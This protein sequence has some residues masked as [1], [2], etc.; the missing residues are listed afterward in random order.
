M[1]AKTC[2]RTVLMSLVVTAFAPVLHA[3]PRPARTV[4]DDTI[5]PDDPKRPSIESVS[6]SDAGLGF[7][8]SIRVHV[9]GL[10]CPSKDKAADALAKEFQ[11]WVLYLDGRP[12]SK[13]H[14]T[15]VDV[16]RGNF[17]FEMRRNDDS[18]EAWRILFRRL[19]YWPFSQPVEITVG[20][21]V[22]GSPIESMAV[23]GAQKRA[24]RLVVV[25]PRRL[26]M[27]AAAYLVLAVFMVWITIKSN[28]L[29][30]PLSEGA[31]PS[32]GA[33]PFS[34]G[35]AQMAAWFM[36]VLASYIFLGLITDDWSRSLNSS[37]LGLMGI[38]A[39]TALS[40]QA[41]DSRKCG[42]ATTARLDVEKLS[43]QAQT[44]T[45]AIKSGSQ[46]ASAAPLATQLQ[47]VHA[48]LSQKQA[49][50]HSQHPRARYRSFWRDLVSDNDGVAL[51]RVQVAVWTL[52]LC[53]TFIYIVM[54]D[55]TMPTFDPTLLTLMGI[56]S[57]TYL[58][59]KLPEK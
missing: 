13:L 5:P 7:K 4:P 23:E 18:A 8:R 33:R 40:A 1:V 22:G 53:V 15:S 19:S 59:F 20:P 12:I 42:A 34:L 41:I 46:E 48:L 38:A 58:G 56:S 2:W 49:V 51:H 57:G 35:R 3:S 37:A 31:D 47:G 10:D 32:L 16:Y 24:F 44:L 30:A 9:E 26:F 43:D 11:N 27:L 39:V 14:P 55:L 6:P 36:V 50:L 21:E 45:E 52:T 25:P 28:M 54:R 29:R 17:D